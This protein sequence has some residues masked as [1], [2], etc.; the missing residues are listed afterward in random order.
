[1]K[2]LILTITAILLISGCIKEECQIYGGTYE[3]EIPATLFPAKD[4]FNIG[5]TITF[6]SEFSDE[7]Y[8]RK[9][10]RYYK[11]RDFKFF[12]QMGIK[13][14]SDSITD[15]SVLQDFQVLVETLGFSQYIYND[16]AIVYLGEYDYS[17][18]MYS[19]SYKFI[20]TKG[21]LYLFGYGL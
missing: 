16:G 20:P 14:I 11:L 4:T 17:E 21:G 7:V 1:M 15:E 8:E 6:T 19:L 13:E 9:T 12:P 10:D 2:Y 18:N 3:F 5:D